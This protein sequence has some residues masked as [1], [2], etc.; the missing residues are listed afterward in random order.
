MS[1]V[2]MRHRFT[3]EESAHEPLADSLRGTG[4]T[5]N[6]VLMESLV[7]SSVSC[8]SG[9]LCRIQK[10]TRR[11]TGWSGDRKCKTA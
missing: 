8:Q 5:S 10:Q 9:E 6:E 1:F 4:R 11:G 2:A 7:K 3:D